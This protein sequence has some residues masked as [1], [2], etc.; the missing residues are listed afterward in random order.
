M[1]NGHVLTIKLD[2]VSY[3]NG[4][5]RESAKKCNRACCDAASHK[6]GNIQ[7]YPFTAH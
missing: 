4:D 3:G 2:N 7:S 5:G 6:P 1:V